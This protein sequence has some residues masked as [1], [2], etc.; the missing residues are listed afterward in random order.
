MPIQKIQFTLTL[1]LHKGQMVMWLIDLITNQVV[2]NME[3]SIL[4]E[5]WRHCYHLYCVHHFHFCFW[6]VFPLFACCCS[7][8]GSRKFFWLWAALYIQLTQILIILYSGFYRLKRVIPENVM[9]ISGLPLAE[10]LPLTNGSPG[11]IWCHLG[12]RLLVFELFNGIMQLSNF[13]I[14]C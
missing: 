8:H 7:L 11:F 4:L 14:N 9:R 6:L 12:L 10:W 13:T 2:K 1:T 5:V 3:L